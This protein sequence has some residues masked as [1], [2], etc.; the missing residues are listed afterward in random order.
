MAKDLG[1]VIGH[2]VGRVARET[3]ETVSSNAHKASNKAAKSPLAGPKGLAAGAGLVA[4]A[5]LAA[6]GAGKVVKQRMSGAAVNPVKKARDAVGGTVKNAVDKKV[7]DAGGPAGIAKEAGKGLIPGMGGKDDKPK[8]AAA[9]GNGRRM[10]VQQAV[11]VAVPI[12]TA[13]NQWTQFEEWPT[14][15]HRLQSVSQE[16]ETHVS[17]KTKIW[18][19]SREF[20]AEIEDQ[21]PD[22]RIKW[23]VTE[24]VSHTGVVTFHQLA[25]R[26]TR[27]D[28]DVFVEPGSL[29]EKAGRGMRHV[30]RAI[31]ADL[32]RFKAYV[33]LEEEETGASRGE[34]DD[35]KVKST[36]RSASASGRSRSASGR[37]STASSGSRSKRASSGSRGT[38]ASSGSRSKSASSGSRNKP[39]A[40]GGRTKSA[41]SGS[42]SGSS[43]GR[44]G[45]N[46]RSGSSGA[47]GTRA[48]SNGQ[49]GSRSG[50]KQTAGS[51]S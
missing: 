10:P 37:R 32:A 11:D 9:I 44:S 18:G 50:R 12:S 43:S 26:L 13:Y 30:K 31:R 3:V 20:K 34:I 49:T 2:T 25:D 36:T 33:E 42:R 46:G 41:S 45:S 40:S 14:F 27:V 21:R 38:S 39:A 47:S 48:A 29:I 1:D 6:R 28:V 19:I 4:L 15:M 5:P 22:E 16:D 35:A 51:R 23:K 24:G 7:E 17:F 8:G